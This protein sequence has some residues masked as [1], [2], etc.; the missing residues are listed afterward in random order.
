MTKK[1]YQLIAGAIHRS[2]RAVEWVEGNK[3]KRE[4]SRS[5]AHLIATDLAATLAHDNPRFDKDKFKE[6]CGF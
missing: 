4:V 3:I 6:A 2:L 5:M 1:D